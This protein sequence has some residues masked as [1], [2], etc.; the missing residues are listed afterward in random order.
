MTF[1]ELILARQSVRRYTPAPVET[2]K[3]MHCLEAARLAPSASN[4]QPWSFIVVDDALM[5]REVARATFTDIQLINRFTLLAPAF[6]VIVIEKAR[7]ITRLAMQVKKKEWPLIDIGIAAEH[8]C[9]QA[10]ELGLGTCM[11]GWFDEKKL[12]KLLHIPAEKSI[13]LI[14]SL[15]YP[16]EG[17]K[18]RIKVRKRLEEITGHNTYR[19]AF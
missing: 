5:T 14:I 3:I 12:K 4:S 7:L 19:G 13:G 6:V 18:L 11:I 10:T 15:G 17:Y 2:V 16:E 1:P 8:F 9:L